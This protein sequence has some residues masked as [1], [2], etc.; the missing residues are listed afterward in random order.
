MS[1]VQPQNRSEPRTAVVVL[2]T[3]DGAVIGSLRNCRLQPL[4]AGSRTVVSAV[5]P[6]LAR[7][8]SAAAVS[9]REEPW[10]AVTYL[11]GGRRLPAGRD[12]R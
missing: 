2:V 3:P 6:P 10:R 9:R 7:S 12:A 4:A 5:R 11:A 1:N 8:P